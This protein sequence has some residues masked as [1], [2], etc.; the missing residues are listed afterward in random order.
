MKIINR[1][2][3]V[4]LEASEEIAKGYLQSPSFCELKEEQNAERGR[5]QSKKPRRPPARR[6]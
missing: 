2:T 4:I 6:R 5:V 1:D 3:G